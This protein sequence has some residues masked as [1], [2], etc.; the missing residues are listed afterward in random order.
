ML[1]PYGLVVG[2]IVGW[3]LGG[4]LAEL[5]N[6]RLRFAWVV[7]L[8]VPLQLLLTYDPWQVIRDPGIAGPLMMLSYVPIGVVVATNLRVPGLGLAGLGLAANLLV[9]LANG[10]LMPVSP[11]SL[12]AAGHAPGGNSIV[13][14]R[15]HPGKD[16]ILATSETRLAFLSDTIV[17]PPIPRPKI[18]SVGDNLTFCGLVFGMQAVMR[19]RPSMLPIL[20]RSAK[21]ASSPYL[22]SH[23][24]GGIPSPP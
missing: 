4:R 12:R 6:L 18:V 19:R 8:V 7:V 20:G 13:G 22:E 1:G 3:L 21:A 15:T 11:E 10:G 17:T 9:M 2:L 5:R 23:P 14:T 16:I 24:T